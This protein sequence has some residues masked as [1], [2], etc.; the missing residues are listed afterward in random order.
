MRRVEMVKGVTKSVLYANAPAL[1][2]LRTTRRSTYL[3]TNTLSKAIDNNLY[4]CDVFLDFS[5]AFDTLL[6]TIL[7]SKLEAY[8]IR[9][10]FKLVSWVSLKQETIYVALGEV[11]SPKQTMLRGILFLF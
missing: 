3:L 8:G 4:T 11:N 10:S 1:S 2:S 6:Y 5:K 7:Q 9:D